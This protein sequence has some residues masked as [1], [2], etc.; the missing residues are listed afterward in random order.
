MHNCSNEF[1]PNRSHSEKIQ[2]YAIFM[3][4]KSEREIDFFL[5]KKQT[6]TSDVQYSD[7]IRRFRFYIVHFMD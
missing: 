2:I 7:K 1:R 6:K 4:K 5:K 3:K